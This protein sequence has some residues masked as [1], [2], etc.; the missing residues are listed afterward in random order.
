MTPTNKFF[1]LRGIFLILP[2]WF[3]NNVFM[4]TRIIWMLFY[5]YFFGLPAFKFINPNNL[6][7]QKALTEMILW[8]NI[9]FGSAFGF[10]SYNKKRKLN[11]KL[12]VS[13]FKF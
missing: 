5:K 6:I 2:I 13:L 3:N 11:Y 7:D 10:H 1:G 4:G 12:L 8:Q 9:R